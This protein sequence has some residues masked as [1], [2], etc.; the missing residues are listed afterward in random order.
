MATHLWL[1][2]KGDGFS[3]ALALQAAHFVAFLKT[4]LVSVLQRKKKETQHNEASTAS[5]ELDVQYIPQYAAY[6]QRSQQ[7]T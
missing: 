2:G 6:I 4:A 5:E 3:L 7:P 1:A